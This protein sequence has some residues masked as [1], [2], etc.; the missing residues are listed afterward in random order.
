MTD[1]GQQTGVPAE[2][3][4]ASARMTGMQVRLAWVVHHCVA[5]LPEALVEC[6]MEI[7][8]TPLA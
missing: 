2:S 1:F 4:K 6:V 5:Q 3:K 8:R 7:V